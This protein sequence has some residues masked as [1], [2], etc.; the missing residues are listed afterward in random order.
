MS[1]TLVEKVMAWS[2]PAVHDNSTNTELSLC[3]RQ[4][5]HPHRHRL[6][7]PLSHLRS[8]QWWFW[9]RC[10]QPMKLTFPC[11]GSQ[12]DCKGRRVGF[13]GKMLKN[14]SELYDTHVD[15]KISGLSTIIE[16]ALMIGIGIVVL[17]VILALYLPIFKDLDF[18][19]IGHKEHW[20]AQRGK[21]ATNILEPRG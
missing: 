11:N 10:W 4:Y 5:L 3:N 12:D 16:P 6:S 21:A 17:I 14:V 19:K 18:C 13:I 20:G 2:L 1:L 15:T 9:D 7:H 8:S